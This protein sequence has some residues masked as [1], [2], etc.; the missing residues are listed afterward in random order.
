MRVKVL[1]VQVKDITTRAGQAMKLRIVQGVSA[2]GEVFRF[3]LGQ[4]APDLAPGDYQVVAEPY[5][6]F[7][8]DLGGRVRF[9]ALGGAK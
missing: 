9:E 4:K 8:C 3:T 6:G 2:S 7:D 1:S 5:I